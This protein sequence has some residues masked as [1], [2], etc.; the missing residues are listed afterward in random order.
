MKNILFKLLFKKEIEFYLKKIGEQ[1]IE[2]INRD[3]KIKDYKELIEKE[4]K[5]INEIGVLKKGYEIIAV[6]TNKWNRTVYVAKNRF[7]NSLD[8]ELYD[9]YYRHGNS[10]PKIECIVHKEQKYIEIANFHSIEKGIK[11]GYILMKSLIS[12]AKLININYLSGE[13]SPVDAEDFD[14]LEGYYK[15]FG[16][17]VSF[18]SKNRNEGGWIK[19]DLKK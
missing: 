13:L 4:H 18:K 10:I 2:I 1:H 7:G 6:D 9:I 8:L 17:E 11:N 14:Y 3:K 16:F 15:R 5:L 12:Y 19:L